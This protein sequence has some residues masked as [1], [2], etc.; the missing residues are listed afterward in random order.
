[1]KPLRLALLLAL[2]CS[3]ARSAK[4]SSPRLWVKR[5]GNKKLVIVDSLAKLCADN[6]L[7]E[8][9]MMAVARGDADDHKG[10]EC[11]EMECDEDEEDEE[12]DEAEVVAEVADD[13]DGDADEAADEAAPA[14]PTPPQLGSK[15]VVGMVAP[16]LGV[17]L[18]KRFD[19]TKPSFLLGLRA[20]FTAAVVLHTLVSFLLQQRIA[21][22]KDETPVKE[23]F[24]PLSMLLGGGAAAGPKTARDYDLAQLNKMTSSFR[25]GVV[26]VA[27]LHWK[28]KWNQMLVYQATQ[29]VVE[30]FYHPL[31]QIHLLGRPTTGPLSRPFGSGGPDMA[32]LFKQMAQPAPAASS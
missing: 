13:S 5:P 9:E 12:A 7:D 4:L 22:T 24:N 18:M 1:M 32:A 8:E 26:V 19:D 30:L 27:L 2:C 23:E 31:V 16:M 3:V 11:G 10:W 6:D 14:A 21:A 28:F 29:Y 17:Q 25:L 15:M 20:V